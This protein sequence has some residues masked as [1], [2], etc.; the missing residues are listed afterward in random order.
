MK[1]SPV[2]LLCCLIGVFVLSSP[3]AYAQSDASSRAAQANQEQ[4]I[5]ELLNEVRQLR[6]EVR[7]I[8][9]NAYRAQA[10]MERVRLHQEQVNRL[11]L[12]LT[13]VQTQLSDL[14][15]RRDLMQAHIPELE[16]K[17]N[18]GVMPDAELK[19]AKQ[20]LEDLDKREPELVERES[21][22]TTELNTERVN[23]GELNRRLDEIERE[24]TAISKGEEDKPG[25]K[26]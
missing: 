26:N 2:Y 20:V 11:T 7:R 23:L 14:R 6:L 12:E 16:Q 9:S 25:K 4:V 13:K 22:L 19:A 17:V 10:T 15:S 3:P 18:V 1:R 24:L 8:T 21:R 5:K